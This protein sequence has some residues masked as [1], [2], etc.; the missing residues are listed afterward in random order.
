MI[1]DSVTNIG[2]RTFYYCKNLKNITIPDSITEIGGEAF[3]NCYS[4][5]TIVVPNSVKKMGEG[6]FRGCENLNSI[7]IPFIGRT[8]G[9]SESYYEVFGYIF[10]CTTDESESGTTEQTYS[11]Q[12]YVTGNYSRYYY[13][14][15]S[16]KEVIITD[17]SVI[18]FG[19]FHNCKYIKRI[20]LYNNVSSIYHHAFY[21]CDSLTDVFYKGTLLDKNNIYIGAVNSAL[22]NAT[23]H[24][25]PCTEHTYNDTCDIDC[26]ECGFIRAVEHIFTNAC[27]TDCNICGVIR[28]VPGHSY[29]LNNNRTCDICKYSK[30]P[31]IPVIESK[32]YNSVTLVKHNG[33][34]YS[35]DGV[36]WQDSNVFTNL[37]AET[38]YT[39][40]QR[41]KGSNIALVSEKSPVLT[42][43]TD[44]EPVYTITFKNWDG[45]ILSTNTYHYGNV[46]TTPSN[47][48]KASDNTYTYTFNGWDKEVVNCNGDAAYTATYKSNY[49][50][51]TI[52]FKNWDGS[53]ISTKT[54]HYGDSVT[55]PTTPTRPNDDK[56][57]YTF[58]SWDK[59]VTNCNGDAVYT[60]TYTA[61]SLVPNKVTS[62]K[63]TIVDNNISK[64]TAGTTVSS[65]LAGLNEGQYCKV[66]NDG[67]QVSGTTA[68]GTG[69][70]VKIMDGNNVKASYTVIVT[71]D[72]NGDGTISVTDMIAIKAHILN[73]STLT[74]VYATAANTNGDSGISITDFIQVKAKILGK[75]SITAR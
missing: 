38:E 7:S 1:P 53:V 66:Y 13:I 70:V 36:N 24:Y 32:T 19:A 39:F 49:I 62:T 43:K 67:A 56:Y 75:G 58:K 48:T 29:T 23:W 47:P 15:S 42:V 31:N 6:V 30:T 55:V 14:P 2:Y 51:Y 16:I 64:I 35:K 50:N 22:E 37:T 3:Y 21:K 65:L 74:G 73:K 68:V 26:N 34:E 41:V 20:T 33:F 4:L 28:T 63:F 46:I 69:M 8:R 9:A 40:Y 27:D 71:G 60:A 45:T 57:S 54:Y 17:E 25:I 11:K 10:G 59:T 72:T 18:S 61:T 5:S 52:T 12:F 44:V